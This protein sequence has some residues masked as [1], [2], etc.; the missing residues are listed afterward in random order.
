[1]YFFKF[2]MTCQVAYMYKNKKNKNKA[3]THLLW[4]NKIMLSI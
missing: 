1:M 2:W 3:L 4:R